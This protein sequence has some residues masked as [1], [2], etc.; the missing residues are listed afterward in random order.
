LGR[1]DL[2]AS[3]FSE[4]APSSNVITDA[5]AIPMGLLSPPPEL[6]WL[7]AAAPSSP[8]G[9]TVVLVTPAESGAL[10][11]VAEDATVVVVTGAAVVVVDSPA[12]P[13]L[14]VVVVVDAPALAVVVVVDAPGWAA[15]VVVVGAAVVGAEPPVT[16][17]TPFIQS[18]GVQW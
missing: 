14:V 11:G 8:L 12:A 16:C 18:C 10:V 17:T 15:V 9:G 4:I 1:Q 3:S 2:A 7:P 13:A 6:P 5:K